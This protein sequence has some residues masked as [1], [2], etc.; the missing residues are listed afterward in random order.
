M[1]VNLQQQMLSLYLATASFQE[2]APAVR[3]WKSNIICNFEGTGG[4]HWSY[5]C[6]FKVLS[7]FHPPV[8][9]LGLPCGFALPHQRVIDELL[10]ILRFLDQM[11]RCWK[12]WNL[13]VNQSPWLKIF[14]EEKTN[15]LRQSQKNQGWIFTL[16]NCVFVS[17]NPYYLLFKLFETLSKHW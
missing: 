1:S 7:I 4:K 12:G 2:P 14:G 6:R 16:K 8:R 11:R 5:L 9:R 13:R 3:P 10:D 15:N 17:E